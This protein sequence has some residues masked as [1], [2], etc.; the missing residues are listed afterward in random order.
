MSTPKRSNATDTAKVRPKHTEKMAMAAI[1]EAR[2]VLPGIQALFGFQLIA[3]FNESFR[4]LEPPEQVLHFV[5]LV[6]VAVAIAIIM[7]PAAY[8]RL[9]ERGSLSA[10]FVQLASWLIAAAMLPLMV[11][12][13][14]EVYLLGRLIL[15]RQ[16]I[17]LAV[18]AVLLIVFAGLWYI[19]PLAMRNSRW[20]G[21]T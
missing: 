15:H 21:R 7:T 5:A 8:G 14:L 10:F 16:L 11:A 1:E 6:L 2:M 13:C 20:D 18:A 4:Q 3:A 17:S 9:V 12:I 19:F